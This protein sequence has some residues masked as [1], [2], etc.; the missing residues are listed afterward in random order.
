MNETR[1]SKRF[2]LQVSFKI[3]KNLLDSLLLSSIDEKLN[4]QQVIANNLIKIS[5]EKKSTSSTEEYSIEFINDTFNEIGQF[6]TFGNEI[7]IF[8]EIKIIYAYKLF[9][10]DIKK[11][12]NLSYEIPING[13]YKWENIVQFFKSKEIDL[14]KIKNYLEIDQLRRVNNFLKHSD[15]NFEKINDIAE[16]KHINVLDF[17]SLNIFYNRILNSHVVFINGLRDEILKDIFEFSNEKIEQIA[18]ELKCKMSEYDIQKLI[19]KLK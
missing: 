15:D 9:E 5:K 16:F 13:F 8:Y 2:K 18:S 6:F 3:S 14:K 11:L 7:Q 10:Y 19:N 4:N 12:I 17:N 1:N